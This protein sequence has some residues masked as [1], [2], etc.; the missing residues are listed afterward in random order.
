MKETRIQNTIQILLDNIWEAQEKQNV[1]TYRLSKMSGVSEAT[2]SKMKSDPNANPTLMT[3]V[4]LINALSLTI[5]FKK[6][7]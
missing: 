7:I 5:C 3:I 6:K 1:S 2:L 4:R